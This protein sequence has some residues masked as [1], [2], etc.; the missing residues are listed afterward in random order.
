M[1]LQ[2]S[3]LRIIASLPEQ[4]RESEGE[5]E[6][7]RERESASER[8]RARERERERAQERE[9]ASERTT[10]HRHPHRPSAAHHP[11]AVSGPCL[12][13]HSTD[14]PRPPTEVARLMDR[15]DCSRIL[16]VD[17]PQDQLRVVI[18]STFSLYDISK[19]HERSETHHAVG[20]IVVQVCWG[21]CPV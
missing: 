21:C 15:S 17:L 14:T 5:R 7:E 2:S 19:A 3:D 1:K 10:R 4:A 20:K 18:D 11:A 16:P 13:T 9:R 12:Y 6:R 8:G